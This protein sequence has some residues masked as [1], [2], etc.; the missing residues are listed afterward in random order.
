MGDDHILEV[1]FVG[2]EMREMRRTGKKRLGEETKR[3]KE[4]ERKGGKR[5]EIREGKRRRTGEVMH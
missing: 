4:E 2:G 5:K 3:R 1:S